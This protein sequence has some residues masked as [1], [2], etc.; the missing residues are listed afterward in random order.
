MFSDVCGCACICTLTFQHTCKPPS[1]Y[2]AQWM[3][4]RVR[5]KDVVWIA[6]YFH[7]VRSAALPHM[8]KHPSCR[9][10]WR[11]EENRIAILDRLASGRCHRRETK[12]VL[13]WTGVVGKAKEPHPSAARWLSL[14]AKLRYIADTR[15][16]RHAPKDRQ[17]TRPK[18]VWE[19]AIRPDD[20]VRRAVEVLRTIN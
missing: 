16:H 10:I 8:P 2:R 4:Y 18:R 9:C 7:G 11:P 20:P 14:R 19:L 13:T 5:P 3:P 17:I 1:K 15:E 6:D 12:C